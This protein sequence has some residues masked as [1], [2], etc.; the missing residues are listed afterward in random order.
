MMPEDMLERKASNPAIIRNH[1]KVKTILANA[2]MIADTERREGRGF[3][4]FIADWP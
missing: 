4:A 3:G 2:A 1:N